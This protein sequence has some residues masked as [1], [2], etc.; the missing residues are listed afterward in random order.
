MSHADWYAN[1]VYNR[2]QIVLEDILRRRI[3]AATIHEQQNRISTWVGL[4]PDTIP[5][6]LEAIAREL[7]GVA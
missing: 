1:G 5:V 7:G 6:P 2:L 3:A 4:L